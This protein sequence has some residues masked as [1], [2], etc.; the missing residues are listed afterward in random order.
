MRNHP[1][2]SAHENNTKKPQDKDDKKYEP[3]AVQKESHD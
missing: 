3:E 1:L 2:P